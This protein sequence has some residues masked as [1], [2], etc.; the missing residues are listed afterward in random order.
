MEIP[1]KS[2]LGQIF[3]WWCRHVRSHWPSVLWWTVYWSQWCFVMFSAFSGFT[4]PSHSSTICRAPVPTTGTSTAYTVLRRCHRYTRR[5]SDSRGHGP[6]HQVEVEPVAGEADRR[7]SPSA[8]LLVAILQHSVVFHL[9]IYTVSQKK[10]C[11]CIFDY[12]FCIFL[13]DLKEFCT[14]D[15]RNILQL[16]I[17]YLPDDIL[18]DI[19]LSNSRKFTS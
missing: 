15:N 5:P 4:L 14:V 18:T 3:A 9:Q 8:F 17:I 12:N 2:D 19:G 6:N 13:V 11:H 10:T 1:L 7:L 16:L